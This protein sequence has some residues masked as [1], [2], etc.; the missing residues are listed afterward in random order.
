MLKKVFMLIGV[1][2]V[3]CLATT[4]QGGQGSSAAASGPAGGAEMR[5]VIVPKVVHPWF[6]DLVN[7]SRLQAEELG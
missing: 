5:I 3:I 4:C 7:Y 1:L 2:C 6:D